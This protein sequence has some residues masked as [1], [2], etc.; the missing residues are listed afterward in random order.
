EGRTRVALYLAESLADN[1][2]GRFLLADAGGARAAL[3]G[4]YGLDHEVGLI[5]VL[6][7][8]ATLAEAVRPTTRENLDVLP[9]GPGELVV[10]ETAAEP[11]IARMLAEVRSD[12][13]AVVFDTGPLLEAQEALVFAHSVQ[14]LLL[15]VL[16][17]ST[18]GEVLAR[19]YRLLQRTRAQ[20]LG[21]VINDPRG[22][23]VRDER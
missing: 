17:G 9:Q 5:Q 14:A 1:L 3:H 15:V 20:V 18:Q 21:V 12:Y 8:E 7:G 13:Q 16:A 23:F 2:A 10:G 11:A 19:A 6:R 4:I 22:E